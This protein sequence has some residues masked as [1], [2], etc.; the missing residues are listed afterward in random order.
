MTVTNQ[1]ILKTML[2][3][4]SQIMKMNDCSTAENFRVMSHEQNYFEHKIVHKRE[5]SNAF[6]SIPKI[7]KRKKR[8]KSAAQLGL[9]LN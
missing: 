1:E 3:Q 7:P 4:Q 6:S 5:L 2:D 8:F 9:K